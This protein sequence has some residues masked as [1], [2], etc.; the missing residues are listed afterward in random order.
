M[1]TDANRPADYYPAVTKL[2]QKVEGQSHNLRITRS[3]PAG[4]EVFQ[5][6]QPISNGRLVEHDL[7]R[8]KLNT[9]KCKLIIVD[10]Q[11]RAMALL[12][13][14]RNL[15]QE[16]SDQRRAPFKDYYERA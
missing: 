4:Q 10:G 12:A 5:F 14:Y 9:N 11:H 6:E 16:W 1:Q 7:T 8:L 15:K 3:G 2:D 13:L